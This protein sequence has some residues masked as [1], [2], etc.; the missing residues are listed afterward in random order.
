MVNPCSCRPKPRHRPRRSESR[1]RRRRPEPRQKLRR[2]VEAEAEKARGEAEAGKAQIE[3]NK[4]IELERL[5]QGLEKEKS[6]LSHKIELQKADM[7]GWMDGYF[8]YRRS[9]L[10]GHIASNKMNII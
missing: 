3:A 7:D 6:E 1:S 4:E 5:W 8:V 2:S 10:K 9:T